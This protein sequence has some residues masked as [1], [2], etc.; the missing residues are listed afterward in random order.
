[1]PDDDRDQDQ[2]VS[3]NYNPDEFSVPSRDAQGQS[4]VVN[5]RVMPS[6]ISAAERIIGSKEFPYP[7]LSHLFRH[8][9]YR[10]LKWL[11]AIWSKDGN[12]PPKSLLRQVDVVMSI[13][14]DE[15][16]NA[17]FVSVFD[18]L[19]RQVEDHIKVGRTGMAVAQISKVIA[20]V[21]D[22]PDGPWRDIYLEKLK[23]DFAHVL[24]T[25]GMPLSDFTK[26]DEK[27]DSEKKEGGA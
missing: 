4:A 12:A 23:T 22:M 27:K 7:T 9:F 19:A 1:M 11:E 24:R 20:K 3:S 25:P 6:Q 16:S 26:S 14:Q 5:F 13:L 21:M 15:D 10:H 18:N 8:A 17:N 2:A